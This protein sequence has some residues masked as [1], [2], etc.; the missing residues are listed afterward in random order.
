MRKGRKGRE[1]RRETGRYTPVA[2]CKFREKLLAAA[3][4][5]E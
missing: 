5:E 3:E 1:K 4:E 2:I